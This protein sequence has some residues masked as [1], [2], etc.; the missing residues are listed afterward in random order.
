MG[1]RELPSKVCKVSPDPYDYYLFWYSLL[2]AHSK[3]AMAA[4]RKLAKN[5][6]KKGL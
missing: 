1:S 3:S 2:R 6:L 4:G 5:S